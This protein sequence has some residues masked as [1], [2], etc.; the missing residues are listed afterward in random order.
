M[1]QALTGLKVYSDRKNERGEKTLHVEYT[2]STEYV[3][4]KEEDRTFDDLTR[5]SFDVDFCLPPTLSPDFCAGFLSPRARALYVMRDG[6]PCLSLNFRPGSLIT[7]P[8]DRLPAALTPYVLRGRR[9][10]FVNRD[11][12]YDD[13]L[14]AR[15]CTTDD[16]LNCPAELRDGYRSDRCDRF[17][18]DFCR[19]DPGHRKCATWLS[20]RRE[21][22]M[23]TYSELCADALD[24]NFCSYFVLYSR[25]EH[26][27]YSD[28]AIERFCG[29]R[30]DDPRCWCVF[31][32]AAAAARVR[33]IE[34]Y[35][36]PK[37]CW[38]HYCTD[39]SRDPKYLLFDQAVQRSKCRYVGCGVTVDQ[40]D[41]RNSTVSIVSDC[42]TVGEIRDAGVE[43]GYRRQAPALVVH[44]LPAIPLIALGA[45][46]LFYLLRLYSA[47]LNA[48]LSPHGRAGHADRPSRARRAPGAAR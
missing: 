25:P 1:G 2:S 30:R 24:Q 15:C 9:C 32:P 22:A 6:G 37:V 16:A 29:A 33:E 39:R 7:T 20:G 21:I 3:Y 35:L 13:T 43:E 4:F 19:R 40:M 23:A 12:P 5:P 46:A 14:A 10:A 26:F 42:L 11:Y 28:V 8:G 44:H 27:R 47:P 31:P 38:L 18:V 34:R 36:G 17:M 45:V 48:G 41:L